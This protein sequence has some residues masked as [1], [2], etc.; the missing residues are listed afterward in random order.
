ME[1]ERRRK[2]PGEVINKDRRE[3]TEAERQ[4]RR[5]CGVAKGDR[6][7]RRG[8]RDEGGEAR[9]GGNGKIGRREAKGRQE[10]KKQIR[11]IIKWNK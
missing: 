9:P 3:F 6:L 8:D 4:G 10:G 11:K 5:R 2:C 7:E 1:G